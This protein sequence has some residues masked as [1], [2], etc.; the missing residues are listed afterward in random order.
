MLNLRANPDEEEMASVRYMQSAS[1]TKQFNYIGN[2]GEDLD[3][4][5]LGSAWSY[6]G[7]QAHGRVLAVKKPSVMEHD[8][9][10]STLKSIGDD[11]G[12]P[13]RSIR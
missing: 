5:N 11:Y 10:L 8:Y 6:E 3:I 4:K 12:R 2:L 1:R 9:E 7:A 13:Y